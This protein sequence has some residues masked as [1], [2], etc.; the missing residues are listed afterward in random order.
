MNMVTKTLQQNQL[1][2]AYQRSILCA[3]LPRA[4]GEVS[5]PGPTGRAAIMRR[6]VDSLLLRQK[7]PFEFALNKKAAFW[8][9]REVVCGKHFAAGKTLGQ[10][11]FISAEHFD[12]PWGG[13]ARKAAEPKKNDTR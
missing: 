5:S 1:F 9:P 13:A 6:R 3:L 8:S 7:P 12:H 10:A 4:P 2:V 11:E